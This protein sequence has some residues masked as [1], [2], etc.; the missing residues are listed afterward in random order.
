MREEWEWEW[1][2]RTTVKRVNSKKGRKDKG[3]KKYTKGETVQHTIT[4][5]PILGKEPTFTHLTHIQLV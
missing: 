1:E 5:K 4:T 2:E 3:R